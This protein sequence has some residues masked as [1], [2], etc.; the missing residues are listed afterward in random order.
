LL[1]IDGLFLL[2]LASFYILQPIVIPP[3]L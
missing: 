3:F 1:T 2:S